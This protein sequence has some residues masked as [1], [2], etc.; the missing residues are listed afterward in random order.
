MKLKIKEIGMSDIE[1]FIWFF[2]PIAGFIL[3][4]II[5]FIVAINKRRD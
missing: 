2:S 3:V 4:N 1:L 5:A